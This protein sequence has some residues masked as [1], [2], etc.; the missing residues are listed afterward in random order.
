M[1]QEDGSITPSGFVVPRFRGQASKQTAVFIEEIP[2][3]DPLTGLPITSSID[4]QGFGELQ[5]LQG[6]TESSL[7]ENNLIGVIKYR[8]RPVSRPKTE[9]SVSFGDPYGTGIWLANEGLSIGEDSLTSYRI[10]G[11]RHRTDGQFRY[12]WNNN[13]PYNASDDQVVSRTNNDSFSHQVLGTVAHQWKHH[14]LQIFGWVNQRQRGVPSMSHDI[15]SQARDNQYHRLLFASYSYPQKWMPGNVISPDSVNLNLSHHLDERHFTDPT[16]AYLIDKEATKL[17]INSLRTNGLFKWKIER[18]YLHLGLSAGHASIDTS[19]YPQTVTSAAHFSRRVMGGYI[20]FSQSLSSMIRWEVKGDQK[21]YGDRLSSGDQD[22]VTDG[23]SLAPKNSEKHTIHSLSTGFHWRLS[24]DLSSFWQVG[25]NHRGPSL[26]EQF[27]NGGVVVGND[28]LEK[29][30]LLHYEVGLIF[31]KMRS[32][33]FRVAARVFQ[34]RGDDKIVFTRGFGNTFKARNLQKTLIRGINLESMAQLFSRVTVG[35]DI[36]HLQPYDLT[37]RDRYLLPN[38]PEWASVLHI[39]YPVDSWT[40]RWQSRHSSQT[41]LDSNESRA[42]PGYLTH[43]IY[44]DKEFFLMND[45]YKLGL[46]IIN[47]TNINRLPIEAVGSNDRGYSSYQTM[48]GFPL[49]P[50]QWKMTLT[51]R[52]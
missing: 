28:L 32:D 4:L 40:L 25:V 34:D 17:R 35:L 50:R 3:S 30:R 15:P 14:R 49:P 11:R 47:I 16:H 22:S 20:G 42:V 27:G 45:S 31:K 19:S 6:M 48:D 2:L 7:P 36:T 23:G 5:I 38:T 24:K 52:L 18:G 29:E 13:T 44:V 21:L 26:L 12:F 10:Y 41:Y 43:D 37:G 33:R 46:A 39:T 9:M 1:L 51:S 8:L